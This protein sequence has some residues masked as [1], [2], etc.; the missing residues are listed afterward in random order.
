[1]KSKLVAQI[2][3][4]EENESTSLSFSTD[5]FTINLPTIL[6]KQKWRQLIDACEN[7]SN[8]KLEF[9]GCGISVEND[10]VVFSTWCG[11]GCSMEYK[12]NAVDCVEAFNVA[13][14]I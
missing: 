8:K 10:I 13:E 11:T 7:R 4:D 6:N 12:M 2:E 1:M 5:N 9:D 3:I 14:Q